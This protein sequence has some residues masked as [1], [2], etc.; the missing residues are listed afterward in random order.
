MPKKSTAHDPGGRVKLPLKKGVVGTAVFGGKDKEYRYR[1]TRTWEATKPYVLFVLMNPSMADKKSDDPTV[2]KCGRYAKAWGYGGLAVANTFA[3]RRT[4]QRGIT[5]ILDPIGPGNDRHIIEMARK[6][7]KVVFA[8]GKPKHKLLRSRGVN[9]VR[10]L[11]DKAQVRPH[12]LALCKDG[13][14][15]HPLYL[16]ST[17]TP[18]V[19]NL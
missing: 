13:T 8:Y 1:L 9:L 16:K 4:D 2:A 3:Y 6:A 14:P 15:K 17:L 11:V 5:E 18:I 12:V 10:I 19:W 7:A